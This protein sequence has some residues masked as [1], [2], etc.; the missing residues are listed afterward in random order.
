MWPLVGDC[1]VLSCCM[2][3]D[4]S[5]KGTTP[6]RRA[7]SASPSCQCMASAARHGTC[8]SSATLAHISGLN[9]Q[10]RKATRVSKSPALAF[11]RDRESCIEHFDGGV[12]LPAGIPVPTAHRSE[13]WLGPSRAVQPLAVLLEAGSA[14][15]KDPTRSR[16]WI[17]QTGK[18]MYGVG[19]H[20][21]LV[22]ARKFVLALLVPLAPS[23]E[24]VLVVQAT[25]NRTAP[26]EPL[27][28]ILPFHTTAS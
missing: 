7:M 1:R 17:A 16:P 11:S 27:R 14:R 19:G 15:T 25:T 21:P 26:R 9:L 20:S 8:I 28:D 2:L 10:L 22:Q 23:L 18:Q 6:A 4:V 12:D 24:V 3:T 13:W 5:E